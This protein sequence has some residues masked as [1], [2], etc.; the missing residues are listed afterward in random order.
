MIGGLCVS[1]TLKKMAIQCHTVMSED[2]NLW[3]TSGSG[4]KVLDRHLPSTSCMS[5]Q[6][7]WSIEEK[8]RCNHWFQQFFSGP[9]WDKVQIWW[10]VRCGIISIK[11]H[12]RL[13]SMYQVVNSPSNELHMRYLRCCLSWW[14]LRGGVIPKKLPEWN[15]YPWLLPTSS[16][17]S[18]RLI[19]CVHDLHP[20]NR[21]CL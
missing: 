15:A 7:C 1:I 17:E 5:C 8:G 20:T 2:V 11:G 6:D 3:Y 9:F 21:N 19:A 16:C 18:L 10:R 13:S 12:G 4:D 14:L